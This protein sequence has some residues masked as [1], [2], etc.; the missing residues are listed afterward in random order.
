M[1]HAS[2]DVGAIRALVG[3]RAD[4]DVH[5]ARVG[6]RALAQVAHF[7][8]D[9]GPIEREISVAGAV[10]EDDDAAPRGGPAHALGAER[11]G[12]AEVS[13]R[14]SD[15]E[16]VR[17][18][19]ERDGIGGEGQEHA[20]LGACLHHHHLSARRQR[21]RELGREGAS[22]I[23]ARAPSIGRGHG[24][25]DVDDHRDPCA[26]RNVPSPDRPRERERA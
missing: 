13:L 16:A 6:A 26:A 18:S 9:R 20:G 24:R 2:E 12:R 8:L 21:A 14:A 19:L 5:D 1:S 7:D 22:P 11:D 23:D 25:G 10:G 4:V 3:A 15:G 17:A